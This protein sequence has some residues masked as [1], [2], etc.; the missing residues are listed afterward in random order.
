MID[1]CEYSVAVIK[2]PITTIS[3]SVNVEPLMTPRLVA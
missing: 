3:T 2:T 1:F